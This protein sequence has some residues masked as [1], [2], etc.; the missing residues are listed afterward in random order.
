[1]DPLISKMGWFP[2]PIQVLCESFS[3]QTMSEL[4]D[5]LN[6]SQYGTSAMTY[7]SRWFET[8]AQQGVLYST[9]D[10]LSEESMKWATWDLGQSTTIGDV[11]QKCVQKNLWSLLDWCYEVQPAP[12]HAQWRNMCHFT[13]HSG[14]VKA[15]QW[16]HQRYPFVNLKHLLEQTCLYGHMEMTQWICTT[17]QIDP[18]DTILAC[19]F[20]SACYGGHL[21]LVRWLYDG[22][23]KTDQIKSFHKKGLHS[24]PQNA[25][26]WSCI[27]G[28]MNLAG[29]L[30]GTV[31]MSCDYELVYTDCCLQGQYDMARWIAQ[32]AAMIQPDLRFHPP[33]P[34]TVSKVALQ[35]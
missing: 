23:C 2:G 6:E 12:F 29:F 30:H 9:T 7:L 4:A 25:L 22:G 20:V 8:W 31:G 24:R 26:Y 11:F 35:C 21:D 18:T 13:L 1:M 32:T 27:N 3:I 10:T 14:Q 5:V 15:L 28:H 34:S 17:T 16:M 19:G 33:L